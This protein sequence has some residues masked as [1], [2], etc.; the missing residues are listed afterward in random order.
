MR[1]PPP[2]QEDIVYEVLGYNKGR[3][4]K[5][6]EAN[7][8]LQLNRYLAVAG[9]DVI[10]WHEIGRT[11]ADFERAL[12]PIADLRPFG[13]GFLVSPHEPDPETGAVPL[14][15]G[16]PLA[17]FLRMVRFWQR[18]GE[19]SARRY[20]PARGLA[21]F[22][23][24]ELYTRPPPAKWPNHEPIA[25]LFYYAFWGSVPPTLNLMNECKAV[26]ALRDPR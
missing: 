26:R 1:A 7:V 12:R 18:L 10:D 22:F 11:A 6:S 4:F 5:P 8:R 16:V 14:R 21:A 20:D 19:D 23:A 13:E 2:T 9:R 25:R 3:S 24:G 15:G 17:V